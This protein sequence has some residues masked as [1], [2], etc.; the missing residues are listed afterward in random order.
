MRISIHTL[1]TECDS[2][3]FTLIQ[4]RRKFQSTH[5]LRSVTGRWR[6]LMRRCMYFNPHTPYGVWQAIS[7]TIWYSIAFQS[8]HS[9]R[10]VTHTIIIN[11]HLI[12]ISI[13]TLLTECD[14][15]CKGFVSSRKD[16]NPHTPYGVWR[17]RRQ[18]TRRFT[19]F[20]PHTPYGVWPIAAKNSDALKLF[21]STHSLRSVTCDYFWS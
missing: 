20:N 10:S 11:S 18:S 6:M 19:N 1:L 12:I 21:Q 4:S 13:H 14:D 17:Q 9:L 2:R 15:T 5:S 3:F 8:T 7:V 16:F